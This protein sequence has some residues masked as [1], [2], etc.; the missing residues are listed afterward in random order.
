MLSVSVSVSIRTVGRRL[1]IAD[2]WLN[3]QLLPCFSHHLFC[4]GIMFTFS[5][6]T[7]AWQTLYAANKVTPS[8]AV[9]CEPVDYIL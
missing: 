1:D 5:K 4:E 9:A 7:L 6:W 8:D 2:T 3:D